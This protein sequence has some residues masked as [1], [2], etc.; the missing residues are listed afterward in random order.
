MD[1]NIDARLD[2]LTERHEALVQTIELSDIR[3]TGPDI[4]AQEL[5]K[6]VQTS[7]IPALQNHFDHLTADLEHDRLFVVPEDDKSVEVYGLHSGKFIHSIK[8]IGVGHSVVYRSD[9]DSP[10]HS[11][12]Q[13]P[14]SREP[15]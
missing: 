11:P 5:A 3:T 1:Y 13:S 2:R 6:D 9:T 12:M 8:G 14:R 7:R 15:Q 10:A 4:S